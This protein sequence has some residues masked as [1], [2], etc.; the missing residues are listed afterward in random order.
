MGR[1][2]FNKLV[3]DN[4]CN[5]L[6]HFKHI[7]QAR[8]IHVVKDANELVLDDPSGV[9]HREVEVL[10]ERALIATGCRADDGATIADSGIGPFCFFR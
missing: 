8:P 3:S 5:C 2:N 9:D 4:D 7:L 10:T 6:K 1:A